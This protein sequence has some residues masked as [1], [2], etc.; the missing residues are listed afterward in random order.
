MAI[1]SNPGPFAN[2]SSGD[3]NRI[4][5]ITFMV[6]STKTVSHVTHPTGSL[7]RY[8]KARDDSIDPD[9]IHVT[10]RDRYID[11]EA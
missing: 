11:E 1:A 7:N 2:S 4:R 10:E 3:V 9:N 5:R 6:S 8:D